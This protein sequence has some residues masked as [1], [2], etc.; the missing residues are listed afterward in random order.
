MPSVTT[1]K[2][3][4]AAWP[5][6]ASVTTSPASPTE[7]RSTEKCKSFPAGGAPN[8]ME[9]TSSALPPARPKEA[10][11]SATTGG[12]PTAPGKRYAEFEP[13]VVLGEAA[14]IEKP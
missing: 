2:M 10:A 6:A 3:S 1:A 12:P 8:I 11:D 14:S 5:C 7:K 9:S 13:P 4:A